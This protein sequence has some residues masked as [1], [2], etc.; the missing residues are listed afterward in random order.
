MSTADSNPNA[1]QNVQKSFRI[2]LNKFDQ[3]GLMVSAKL[4]ILSPAVTEE[5]NRIRTVHNFKPAL[6][7]I[8]AEVCFEVKNTDP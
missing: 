5:Y 7:N 3:S 2:N 4:N 1:K 6:H 8:L